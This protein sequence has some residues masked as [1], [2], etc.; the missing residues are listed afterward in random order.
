M[1]TGMRSYIYDLHFDDLVSLDQPTRNKLTAL[2]V[3]PSKDSF[4]AKT[5]RDVRDEL[6]VGMKKLDM[7]KHML[8]EYKQD[9]GVVW[10]ERDQSRQVIYFEQ[11]KMYQERQELDRQKQEWHRERREQEK[12]FT[13]RNFF[14][15][16]MCR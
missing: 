14:E 7:V 15:T 8:A 5:L 6:V 11:Q 10:S 13:T 12:E 1:I 3:D 2:I 9:M 16:I 4:V